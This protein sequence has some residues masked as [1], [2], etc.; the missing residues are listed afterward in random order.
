MSAVPRPAG[1]S[2]RPMTQEDVEAVIGVEVRSYEFPWTEGIFRDCL[3]VGY[4]CWLAEADSTLT[5]YGIMSVAAGESHILNLC[6]DPDWQ[7][8]GIGRM[9][10]EQMLRAA[11]AH[12]AD[13]ALLEVRPSNLAALRLYEQLGFNQYSVR[14]AYYPSRDG[15]EDALMLAKSL[16]YL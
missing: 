14:R 8:R 10:L 1:V 7:G 2:L 16:V 5:G 9:L 6:V 12:G 4:S 11:R 13:I 3:Q 15:R